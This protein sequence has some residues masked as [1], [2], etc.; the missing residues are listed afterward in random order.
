MLYI[1]AWLLL[2]FVLGYIHSVHL[3]KS[4]MTIHDVLLEM[5]AGPLVLIEFYIHFKNYVVITGPK[6]EIITPEAP[7]ETL[8][9]S[10]GDSKK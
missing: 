4:T 9:R 7:R 8:Q 10:K 5:L 6:R 3:Q 1:L 2:G